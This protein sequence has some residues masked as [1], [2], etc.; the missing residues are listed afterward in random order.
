MHDMCAALEQAVRSGHF[1]PNT[2]QTEI[3][4]I[5]QV[6]LSLEREKSPDDDWR[7]RVLSIKRDLDGR[8]REWDAKKAEQTRKRLGF[9]AEWE[10]AKAE[11]ER[12]PKGMGHRDSWNPYA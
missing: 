2:G 8:L 6:I 12:G 5:R 10:D 11:T 1:D 9:K 7:E 4:A 3:I